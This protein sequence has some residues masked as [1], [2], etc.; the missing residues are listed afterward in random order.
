MLVSGLLIGEA[1]SEREA[2]RIAMRYRNCPYVNLMATKGH[3]TYICLTLPKKQKWWAEFIANNPKT[4][5]G[6]RKA[7]IIFF[8]AMQYPEQLT[9]H[10][11]E[12]PAIVSPCGSECG[13][14]SSYSEC[15]GCPSTVFY[16]KVRMAEIL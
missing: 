13:K 2:Q 8:D 9:M 10:L 1:E 16:E 12:K 11:P 5:F 3:Q 6:L 7:D 4:T 14:C 15:S